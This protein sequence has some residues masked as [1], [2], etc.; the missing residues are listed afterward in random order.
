MFGEEGDDM[1][2]GAMGNDMM[3]GGNGNDHH[4]IDDVGNDKLDGGDDSD[5]CFDKYGDNS[6]KECE[7]KN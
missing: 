1:L 6:F 5:M 2:F 3:Y 4:L 7:V